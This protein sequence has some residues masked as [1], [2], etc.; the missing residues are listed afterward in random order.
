MLLEHGKWGV[1][2]DLDALPCPDSVALDEWL[3]CFPHFAFLLAGPVNRV[4]EVRAAFHARDLEAEAI[5]TVDGTGSI[6]IASGG[7]QVRVLDLTTE[8][9]TGL[10]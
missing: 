5:G 9:I 6:R 4:D 2:V 1:E 8:A 7:E 10:R 3:T